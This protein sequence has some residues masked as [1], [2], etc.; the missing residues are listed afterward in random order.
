MCQYLRHIEKTEDLSKRTIGALLDLFK[1]LT[2]LDD[3]ELKLS[4]E[5]RK[6]LLD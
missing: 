4:L 3:R 2:H 1:F 5:R 6:A